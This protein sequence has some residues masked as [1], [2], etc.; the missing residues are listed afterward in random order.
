MDRTLSG[1]T[2]SSSEWNWEWWQRRS[3]QHSPKLQHYWNLAIRL[4]NVIS[5]T[6]IGGG[7]PLWRE[8]VG[9]FHSPRQLRKIL[10]G[11]LSRSLHFMRLSSSPVDFSLALEVLFFLL[12]WF[13]VFNADCNCL[14]SNKFLILSIWLWMYFCYFC[15]VLVSCVFFNVSSHCCSLMFFN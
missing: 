3:N 9:I 14:F 8:A 10:G 12:P 6:V 11:F 13:S 1:T 7:L 5:I 4:F 2:A 15:Y